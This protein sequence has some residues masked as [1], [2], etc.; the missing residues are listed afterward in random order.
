M[1]KA[2]IH[3]LPLSAQQRLR[4]VWASAQTDLSFCSAHTHFVD[5]LHILRGHRNLSFF[6]WKDGVYG[7]FNTVNLTPLH[8]T[9]VEVQTIGAIINSVN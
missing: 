4:S 6:T 9:D 3:S 5:N 2:W 7:N 1:E 8:I